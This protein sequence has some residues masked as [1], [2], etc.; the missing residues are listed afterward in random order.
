MHR[1]ANGI[2]TKSHGISHRP[3]LK[4]RTTV[5]IDPLSVIALVKG[6]VT[7][8][9]EIKEMRGRKPN[10]V[11]GNEAQEKLI[12]GNHEGT[13]FFVT[14]HEMDSGRRSYRVSSRYPQITQI[15]A[16]ERGGEPATVFETGDIRGNGGRWGEG[17]FQWFVVPALAGFGFENRSCSV[18][19]LKAVRRTGAGWPFVGGRWGT[20]HERCSNENRRSIGIDS[21][22]HWWND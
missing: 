4:R 22:Q 9:T 18:F 15:S 13:K 1:V 6:I 3:I 7:K 19:R 10:E 17:T 21:H 5:T 14:V 16:E 12:E 8:D 2:T 11:I 20:K